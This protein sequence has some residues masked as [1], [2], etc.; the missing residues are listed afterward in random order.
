MR[1]IRYLRTPSLW[2]SVVLLFGFGCTSTANDAGQVRPPAVAG[3]FYPG[4]APSL[5]ALLKKAF[6]NAPQPNLKGTIKALILPH[7]GYIYS[8]VLAAIGMRTLDRQD[9]D[10][11]YVI[12]TSHHADVGGA[13]AWM[14]K[15]FH[16]PLGDYPVDTEAVKALLVACPNIR[17][18]P[19]AW[20]K[21]H[22]VEVQV[23]FLQKAA[24]H[25][26]LVPLIMGSATADEIGSVARAIAEQAKGRKAVLIASAD[27]AHYPSYANAKV[28]DQKTIEAILSLDPER[29]E[30]SSQVFLSKGIPELYCTTCGLA[31]IKTVMTASTLL[32]GNQAQLLHYANSGDV[33]KDK[34]RV[35]GY[36]AIAIVQVPGKPPIRLSEAKAN[37]L[38]TL[39]VGQKAEL[40]RIARA[41][42]AQGLATG[43]QMMPTTAESVFL[44]NRAVFV[45]LRKQKDLRGCIG[46]TEA[47]LPLYQAVAQMACAAAFEDPR[48]KP[49]SAEELPGIEIEISVLTPLQRIDRIKDITLGVH[50][51]AVKR[52]NRSGLFLPQVASETG[53]TREEFLNNLCSQ[54]A[55]LPEDSWRDRRTELYRFRVLSF[56]EPLSAEAMP[57]GE[58][59]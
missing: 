30:R 39:T 45:T 57:P 15:A 24:P 29:L 28:L 9:L 2:L 33:T 12:G 43:K 35:V 8:G 16:T 38:Q 4:D 56:A 42:I 26:K 7:A 21:E 36:A 31:A 23:P 32:G 37:D 6:Y 40:L 44:Q 52:G 25:A 20:E 10:T 27:L 49:V 5:E 51:V 17:L 48:F 41:A 34:T 22:S 13:L 59:E 14:G 3:A 58:H 19:R 55:G 47:R 54:K 18:L 46:L 11:I 1:L 53:W 50:G